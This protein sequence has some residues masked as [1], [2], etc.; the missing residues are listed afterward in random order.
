L[1]KLKIY[2]DTISIT[3]ALKNLMIQVMF[4]SFPNRMLRN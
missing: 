4:E 2:F 1:F 3:H